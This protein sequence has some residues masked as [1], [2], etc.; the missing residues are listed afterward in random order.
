M[1]SKINQLLRIIEPTFTVLALIQYSAD[2]MPLILS[3][4]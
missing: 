3:G 2:W 4:A 1:N